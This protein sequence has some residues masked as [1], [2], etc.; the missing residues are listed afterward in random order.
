MEAER[1]EIVFPRALYT[2]AAI[3]GVGYVVYW[4]RGVLTPILLAFAIAYV[5]DPVVDRLEAW[6]VPRP[7]GIA[8]VMLANLV[9]IALFVVLVIPTI[10]ADIAGVAKELP[11]HAARWMGQAEHYVTQYGITI[12][13]STT[14][15]FE[16]LRGHADKIAANVVTPVGTALTWVVGGTASAIGAAVG[17]MIV[18]VLAVY[19]LYDFDKITAGIRD[20]IPRRFRRTVTSYARDIDAVL[21]QF[22]RGQLIV[23]AILAVLYGG[24]Y[25]LLG[26]RLAVPIGITAGIL[27]FVPYLGSAFA[28]VAGLLMS[29]VGGGGWGATGRRRDRLLGHSESRRVRDHSTRGRQRGWIARRLGLARVVR[30]RRALRVPGGSARASGR[31][32]RQDLRRARDASTTA[33][34]NCFSQVRHHKRRR[35]RLPCRL[36]L[37]RCH[38][39]K[40]REARTDAAAME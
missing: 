12:P 30:R 35:R 17:A 15:W 19:L 40:N 25:T 32:D 22:I 33:R 18:P 20:L 16:Q 3:F 26:V 37:A 38:P 29:L 21:G 5:F 10:V 31:C 2:A 34:P 6:K 24:A 1:R 9:A 39:K 14:E 27:N 13:H 11:A 28:L 7:L 4:L 36:R 23:M 8:I